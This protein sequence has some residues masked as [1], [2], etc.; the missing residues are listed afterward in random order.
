MTLVNAA[1]FLIAC[2]IVAQMITH[3][4]SFLGKLCGYWLLSKK[5]KTSK[6]LRAGQIVKIDGEPF[7]LL[8]ST[9]VY[10]ESGENK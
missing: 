7:E 4:L 8:R 3:I 1:L 2:F 6:I 9:L 10:S 5:Y